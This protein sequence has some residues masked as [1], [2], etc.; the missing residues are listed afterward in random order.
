MPDT[1]DRRG[2]KGQNQRKKKGDPCKSFRDIV[3]STKIAFNNMPVTPY[4]KDNQG[5]LRIG[6]DDSI[7]AWTCQKTGPRSSYIRSSW[8]NVRAPM[9]GS[10]EIDVRN[11]KT[12]V[13][14]VLDHLIEDLGLEKIKIEENIDYYWHCPA[15]EIHDM[16]KKPLGLDVGSLRDDVDFAKL[17]KRGQSYDASYNLVHIAPLLRYIGE[18]VKR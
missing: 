1:A 13:N 5:I 10:N 4:A 17:I 2:R 12:A 3:R 7:I 9:G 18:K 16:S 6:Y 11:L 15:S 14:A 8:K